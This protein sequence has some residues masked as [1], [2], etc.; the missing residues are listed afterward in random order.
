MKV[1]LPYKFQAKII[2]EE[3]RTTQSAL[4]EIKVWL[5]TTSLPQLQDEF[6]A[7][8]LSSCLNNVSE[9]KN[10]IQAYFRIKNSAPEIFN[11][12][13][14]DGDELKKAT[15]VIASC[16]IHANMESKTV[17]HFFKLVDSDYRNF[18]LASTFKI[19]NML[20]DVSQRY[21][22]PSDMIVVLDL[23]QAGWMH[24]TCL[25]IG[26][27][28]TY[29]DFIQ[30]AIPLKIQAIHILNTSFVVA[31]AIRVAKMFMKSELM[32]TVKTHLPGIDMEEFFEKYV[33]ASSLPKDCGGDL[34]SVDE[35]NKKTKEQFRE[36]KEFYKM[37]EELRSLK[38][39][40]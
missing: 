19:A 10:T 29:M 8:F 1:N 4:D 30:Q 35:L 33:P 20:V 13:D 9:T 38:I 25:K 14:V 28:K 16:N 26:L 34:P 40:S 32:E 36:L 39:H 11:D 3:G 37:E 24:L 18:S 17:I 12:R 15:N 21:N 7:L 22:P 31:K 23:G 27:V 5:S 6:I 2:I